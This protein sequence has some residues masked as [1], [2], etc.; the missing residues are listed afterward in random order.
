MEE[1]GSVFVCRWGDG[2]VGG[3]GGCYSRR[4]EVFAPAAGEEGDSDLWD[5]KIGQHMPRR[6][7]R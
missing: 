6:V 1:E 2:E 3:E 7:H 4:V 5:S